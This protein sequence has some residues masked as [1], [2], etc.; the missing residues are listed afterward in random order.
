MAPMALY[1][2]KQMQMRVSDAFLAELDD[3]RRN[4]ADIPSRAEAIR[5]LIHLGIKAEPIL[6]D[7]LRLMEHLRLNAP[8]PE[9]DKHIADIKEALGH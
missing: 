6:S 2:D 7:L 3:W 4:Q 5:R 8:A 1:H 9:L